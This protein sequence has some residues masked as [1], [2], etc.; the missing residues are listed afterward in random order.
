MLKR[1]GGTPAQSFDM[2]AAK[3]VIDFGN[4]GVGRSF[5]FS[6]K[7]RKRTKQKTGICFNRAFGQ[8]LGSGNA[9]YEHE[10]SVCGGSDLFG[11]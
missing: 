4:K 11:Y 3:P 7:V 9:R 6:R 2:K 5:F 10:A 1:D 8:N